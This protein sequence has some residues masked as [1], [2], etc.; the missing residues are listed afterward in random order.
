MHNSGRA[1]RALA[2]IT[3]LVIVAGAAVHLWISA[4]LGIAMVAAGATG[5]VV[6]GALGYHWWRRR[7]GAAGERSS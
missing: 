7:R 4:S 1:T 3:I 5:H 6:A 2:I